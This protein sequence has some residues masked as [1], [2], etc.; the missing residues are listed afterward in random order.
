[1]RK[2][3]SAIA[4]SLALSSL[5]QTVPVI[6]N[7]GQIIDGQEIQEEAI[8]NQTEDDDFTSTAQDNGQNSQ[9][10]ENNS[11]AQEPENPDFFDDIDSSEDQDDPAFDERM[12][13]QGNS[14]L[15]NNS[16]NSQN[17]SDSDTI[18]FNGFNRVIN[19]KDDNPDSFSPQQSETSLTALD[20]IL[21]WKNWFNQNSL[22]LSAPNDISTNDSSTDTENILTDSNFPDKNFQQIIRNQLNKGLND[23]VTRKELEEVDYLSIEGAIIH[24]L[25]GIN[26]FKGL[27]RLE[28]SNFVSLPE[29]E[30]CEL[31]ELT[32]LSLNGRNL[33]NLS[34]AHCP[35][36]TWLY[37]YG[38]G[39]KN[40]EIK[41]CSE[42]QY[43]YCQNNAIKQLKLDEL[44]SLQELSCYNNQLTELNLDSC[45]STL[46]KLYC[47]GNQLTKLNLQGFHQLNTLEAEGNNLSLLDVSGCSLL[48][49]LEVSNQTPS[50]EA[51]G[52]L[53]L[54]LHGCSNL[55]VLDCSR[56]RMKALILPEAP[57]LTE[58][59]CSYNQLTHLDLTSYSK[60][61]VLN[62]WNN[63]LASLDLSQNS[64]LDINRSRLSPQIWYVS[65]DAESASLKAKDSGAQLSAVTNVAPSI[66]SYNPQTGGFDNLVTFTS[67][68]SESSR[69]E[70]ICGRDGQFPMEVIFVATD[71]Q[72]G[73]ESIRN[74]EVILQN[75]L[76]QYTGQPVE[77][78]P[79]VYNGNTLL[80]ENVDYSVVYADNTNVGEALLL[81]KGKGD[82]AGQKMITF[83]IAQDIPKPPVPDWP[84][85]NR[86]QI[87]ANSVSGIKDSYPYGT[88]IYSIKPVVTVK[89]KV[90]TEG[91]DYK[92]SY[93]LSTI[94]NHSIQV[95]GIGNYEGSVIK[96]FTIAQK[97]SS[98][99]SLSEARIYGIQSS[100]PYTGGLIKPEPLVVVGDKVL[101]KGRDYAV[102]YTSNRNP[103]IATITITGQGNYKGTKKVMFQIAAGLGSWDSGI[104][105]QPSR[106]GTIEMFRL[107]NPNSGEHF[108]TGIVMEAQSLIEQGW[109][110]EGIAWYTPQISNTPVYR[111]Y[112]QKAGDHFYT[113][114]LEEC[115]QLRSLGWN[116]EGI[117][118]YAA[119]TGTAVYRQ[120]NPNARTGAHNYTTDRTE[121]NYLVS[122]GWR[123][124]GIAWYAAR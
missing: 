15:E 30:I 63:Q 110:Y 58:L 53:E 1:M 50:P 69:Y 86:T 75:S 66:T 102:S 26:L 7:D 97:P 114:S 122:H 84:D 108:Y 32:S 14:N 61:A 18:L 67:S 72:T 100:Y 81:V 46:E 42:V 27:K 12:D 121:H 13:D 111:L 43:L 64:N 9:A 59:D 10:I 60:L 36:L 55:G 70:Y 95:T 116:Y 40:L 5:S 31:S 82:Y 96:N 93:G 23:S 33:D 106:K 91:K 21:G 24:D 20:Q 98:T 49:V 118:W 90:L 56:S 39:I 62:C 73:K 115:N 124:E 107:Y 34:L 68:F 4:L 83:R 25:K 99:T 88:D 89:G 52:E 109:H 117:G 22:K 19:G 48:A 54:N 28:I 80:K 47:E 45:R 8:L 77:P 104:T 17:Q 16:D 41:D 78:K 112:N 37:I 119:S 44:Q 11:D 76:Y 35:K 105:M 38:C 79:Q 85:Q 92:L 120:Y 74:C 103:G 51:A 123:N 94:G 65:P 57:H 101:K 2:L 87:T 6:A 3:Q 113:A 29:I 71:E